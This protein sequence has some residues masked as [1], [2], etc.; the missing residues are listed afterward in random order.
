MP[1]CS[2]SSMNVPGSTSR[3]DALAGGQLAGVVLLGDLLVAAAEARLGAAVFE[4][5]GERA[6]DRRRAD[7]GLGVAGHGSRQDSRRRGPRPVYVA[8]RTP[9]RAVASSKR[10][11][12][13]SSASSPSGTASLS[14]GL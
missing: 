13:R 10:M 1:A 11:R 5:G 8:G 6:Q 3:F 14:S 9:S 2:P 12:R 7:G 4:V